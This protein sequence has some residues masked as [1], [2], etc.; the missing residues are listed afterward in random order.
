M[1]RIDFYFDFISPYAYL[2]WWEVTR[3]ARE[4]GDDVVPIPVLF[5]GLLQHHGQ[6][7]PAEIPAKRAWLVRDTLR[8]AQRMAVPFTLPATHPFRPVTALRLALPEVAGEER[9]E[10]VEAL[11]RHGWQRGG[12]LGEDAALVAALVAAGLDGAALLARAGEPHAKARLREVTEAAI[13]R[14]VFGVPTMVA[15]DEL[16]WGSDRVDDVFRHLD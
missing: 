8:Q 11:W 5:A 16:F 12:E 9:V 6:R 2:A 3:R 7:G 15:A 1:A 4:R 10:V 14:G 13:A